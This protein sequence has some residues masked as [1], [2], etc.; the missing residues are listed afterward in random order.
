MST[1]TQIEPSNING[2]RF[3]DEIAKDAKAFADEYARALRDNDAIDNSVPF[4]LV[5]QYKG[6]Q[7]EEFEEAISESKHLLAGRDAA[8]FVQLIQ[9]DDNGKPTINKVGSALLGAAYFDEGKMH[10]LGNVS[11]NLKDKNGS[12]LKNQKDDLLAVSVT[13]SSNN[14][15]F[16]HMP[17]MSRI[18]VE[19]RPVKASA[20]EH[21]AIIPKGLYE[22]KEGRY[23][24]KD[25]AKVRAAKE[26]EFREQASS[27]MMN[28]T[29]S[30]LIKNAQGTSTSDTP[31]NMTQL[32][33]KVK[34]IWFKLEN[35]FKKID[36]TKKLSDP[37]VNTMFD[38]GAN[39]AFVTA[40][41]KLLV[42]EEV[43]DT[44]LSIAGLDSTQAD[45]FTQV[46]FQPKNGKAVR[47]F[48]P[49]NFNEWSAD[50]QG[51][52]VKLNESARDMYT[53]M[54]TVKQAS[55]G[56]AFMEHQDEFSSGDNAE[57][58][59]LATPMADGGADEETEQQTFVWL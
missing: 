15:D 31:K 50:L 54:T 45:Y 51:T 58:G 40:L 28:G 17:I 27:G 49:K 14:D 11:E 10:Q 5:L 42:R 48:A 53:K 55:G 16:Q 32:T 35:F 46:T 52:Y 57:G 6:G 19:Y 44:S 41:V 34:T 29:I 43:S 1:F 2:S 25:Q 7:N 21:Y 37:D 38:S 30:D 20:P 47:I 9:Q 4:A 23:N 22:L 56:A 39:A 13:D 33:N 59:W 12:S 8:Q 18:V 36:R 3:P 26:R 24:P